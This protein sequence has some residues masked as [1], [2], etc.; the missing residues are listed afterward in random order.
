MLKLVCF[1][2]H[3]LKFG[4]SFHTLSLVVYSGKM[5]PSHLFLRGNKRASDVSCA[6][7]AWHWVCISTSLSVMRSEPQTGCSPLGIVSQA[8]GEG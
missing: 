2:L 4:F 1:V 7:V 6:R 8:Q 3:L 5:T